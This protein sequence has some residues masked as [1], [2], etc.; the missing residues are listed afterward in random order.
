MAR[1]RGRSGYDLP[2]LGKIRSETEIDLYCGVGGAESCE[3]IVETWSQM[4]LNAFTGIKSHP[5]AS[6]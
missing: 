4:G 3:E 5:L 2:R 6:D 1:L